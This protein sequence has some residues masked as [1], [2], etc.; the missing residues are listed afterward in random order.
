MRAPFIEVD[1]CGKLSFFCSASS[2]DCV[3]QKNPGQAFKV[4]PNVCVFFKC[5]NLGFKRND[6]INRGEQIG[7]V[8]YNNQSECSQAKNG[9]LLMMY[10]FVHGDDIPNVR[11]KP[12][13]LV[14]CSAL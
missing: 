3:I 5:C 12:L 7:I 8:F 13:L 14:L 2:S 9:H 4:E 1:F 10:S 6:R 11:L